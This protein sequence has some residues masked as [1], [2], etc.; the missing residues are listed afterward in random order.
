MVAL[1]ESA[2]SA[3]DISFPRIHYRHRD[4]SC[5]HSEHTQ[6]HHQREEREYFSTHR[7]RVHIPV[8]YG[9]QCGER[10]PERV[11]HRS[12]SFWLCITLKEIDAHGRQVEHEQ[13]T[14][15]KYRQIHT[16]HAKGWKYVAPRR[17]I[18]PV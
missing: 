4:Q 12:K 10:P 17:R 14:H 11:E 6:S 15:A 5:R 3:I 13:S 1:L 18:V 2:C 7:H 8:A 9:G 16:H